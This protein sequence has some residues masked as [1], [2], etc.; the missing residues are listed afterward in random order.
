MVVGE[1]FLAF[2]T[3]ASEETCRS[4]PALAESLPTGLTCLTRP[5]HPSPQRGEG[6]WGGQEDAGSEAMQA[7]SAGIQGL[8]ETC[9]SR[10]VYPNV[11]DGLRGLVGPGTPLPNPLPRGRGDSGVLFQRAREYALFGLGGLLVDQTFA[12]AEE[13][14]GVVLVF[15]FYQP[16]EVARVGCRDT[17]LLIQVLEVEVGASG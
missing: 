10:Q 8:V 7:L 2:R 1:Q 15:H 9:R 6:Q 3:H 16:G 5:A 12:R 13:V 11:L 17:R 4:R 14:V